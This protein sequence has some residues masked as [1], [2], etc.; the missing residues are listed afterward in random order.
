MSTIDPNMQLHLVAEELRA[1][2]SKTVVVQDDRLVTVARR[3][4]NEDELTQI[5]EIARSFED[6]SDKSTRTDI[7]TIFKNLFRNSAE[8]KEFQE[9]ETQVINEMI[10]EDIREEL[11]E[12]QL[13]RNEL[14]L[15]TLQ[16]IAEEY[17]DMILADTADNH[18]EAYLRTPHPPETLTTEDMGHTVRSFDRIVEDMRRSTDNMVHPKAVEA[19]VTVANRLLAHPLVQENEELSKKLNDYV[20]MAKLGVEIKIE[21]NPRILL[22]HPSLVEGSQTL[23]SLLGRETLPTLSSHSFKADEFQKDPNLDEAL[24]ICNSVYAG[25]EL[26]IDLAKKRDDTGNL[27]KADLSDV[28]DAATYLGNQ[29]IVE[30]CKAHIEERLNASNPDMDEIGAL[31]RSTR[32]AGLSDLNAL[33]E[34]EISQRLNYRLVSEHDSPEIENLGIKLHWMRII[35]LTPLGI[36][37]L[38]NTLSELEHVTL[39]N[40]RP[41]DAMI[42]ELAKLTKLH[43]VTLTETD[44]DKLRAVT[45][46]LEG[47][48]HLTK[49]TL[50]PII[51]PAI[52]DAM[53]ED[54]HVRFP[55]VEIIRNM[56]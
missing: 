8:H 18:G 44:E 20:T 47:L 33:C 34:Q 36:Q 26:R 40:A 6:L 48:P 50:S 39:S 25:P 17:P 38:P 31:H 23:Q 3:S 54:F 52:N 21:G 15:L 7:K 32:L 29:E 16:K 27:V 5:S 46:I 35:E 30:F 45:A 22:P 13:S 10:G 43:E 12:Q 2:P 53:I 51:S 49:L 56:G 14:E 24:V 9:Y 28:I 1:D 11:G 55:N 19:M 37:L 4:L 42:T 41:L